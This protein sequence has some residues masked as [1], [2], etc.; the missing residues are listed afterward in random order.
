MVKFLRCPPQR[1]CR[2]VENSNDST[3][4]KHT[5]YV[6]QVSVH[7]SSGRYLRN[8][9]D[10]ELKDCVW[11]L[12]SLSP[13]FRISWLINEAVSTS[14]WIGVYFFDDS[15]E[16]AHCLIR[17]NIKLGSNTG[18]TMWLLDL[19]Q[20]SINQQDYGRL[21][22]F[23]YY[24]GLNLSCLAQSKPV[25]LDSVYKQSKSTLKSKGSFKK[26]HEIPRSNDLLRIRDKK[27]GLGSSSGAVGN[28]SSESE[29][30]VE[31]SSKSRKKGWRLL[32][33]KTSLPNGFLHNSSTSSVDR[34]EDSDTDSSSRNSSKDL[35]TWNSHEMAQKT[36]GLQGFQDLDNQEYYHI[37]SQRSGGSSSV[38]ET[39]YPTSSKCL[40]SA[41]DTPPPPLPPR[42]FLPRHR[43]LERTRAIEPNIQKPPEVLRKNKPILSSAGPVLPPRPKKIIHPEDTFGFEIV[44]T[45]ELSGISSSFLQD[46]FDQVPDQNLNVSDQIVP[47]ND[48]NGRPVELSV[49][50][51]GVGVLSEVVI[52]K[53]GEN[54]QRVTANCSGN[55]APG[56][57][58]STT[59]APLATPE[60]EGNLIDG[61]PSIDNPTND[62]N[63]HSV[64]SNGV[65]RS[66]N[67]VMARKLFHNQDHNTISSNNSSSSSHENNSQINN[68]SNNNVNHSDIVLNENS[69]NVPNLNNEIPQR[70]SNGIPEN[71]NVETVPDKINTS[72]LQKIPSKE[73]ISDIIH[74]SGSNLIVPETSSSSQLTSPSM[75]S[76]NSLTT[77]LSGNNLILPETS[78]S[79]SP[80]PVSPNSLLIN[81]SSTSES[82]LT[83]SDNN[84]MI[85]SARSSSSDSVI[86][87]TTENNDIND[88]P[89]LRPKSFTGNESPSGNI[90]THKP[91]SR[92]VSH[93]PDN[94][95][96][97]RYHESPRPQNR[98][99]NRVQAIT[100]PPSSSSSSSSSSSNSNNGNI[101][102]NN[103][104]SNSNNCCNS[105]PQCPPTPTHHARP[106][107]A[108]FQSPILS[109]HSNLVSHQHHHQQHSNNDLELNVN[110]LRD[111][112]D[113]LNHFT[114]D[115]INRRP[116]LN[117]AD[118][119]NENTMS[120]STSLIPL[121]SAMSSSM[122]SSSS[123]STGPD[124]I[125]IPVM[126]N[127]NGQQTQCSILPL[128]H[129][130]TSRLPSIPE[131][132]VR[133]EHRLDIAPDEESLPP[134][135][136]ARIDSHGRIFYIDHVNRM[137]TWQRPTHSSVSRVRPLANE[138]QRQQL[139]RR[140][141]S[142]RRTIT[143][144]RMETEDNNSDHSNGL[145][146][147]QT[148][149][150]NCTDVI[151]NA[152][153]VKF[154]A[155]PDFFSILHMNQD[156]LAL[157]NR[158][159]S[160]KHMVS[161]IRRDPSTFERYQHN[162]D[163]VALVNLFADS[164][165]D[166]PRGWETKF[167]RN[168]KAP[169]PPPR[170]PAPGTS[171]ISSRTL[172]IPTAYN[173]KVVA[174][175]RQPNIIDILKERH[176]PLGSNQALRDKV[177]AVR[178]EGTSALD[179][180]SHDIDLT[181]LLSLFEQEIMSYVP[182]SRSSPRGSPQLS[183]Q[184]SPG[185]SRAN[186]RAPAPYR[187]D[188]EAKLRNF[189]RKLESK[190]YGQGPGKLKLNIRREN[191][192]E[193]AF[194]KIMGASK[195]D[196]QKCKLYIQFDH[197]EGLDYGGPS[198]EFF[199]LLSRELFNPYYGLFEYSANDT[200]T[201]QVSPMSAFVDNQHE[202]F[203][204]SGR[205]LGLALVHQY[206]LDAFFTRPF[207]KA[208]L[209]LPVSLSDLESLDGEFH[210][211]LLWIKE[212][213]I[214]SEVLDLTFAVT[215]EV[216]GQTVERE[217]KPGG[218]N[219]PV[220]EK[221]KK[222]Y[223]ERVVRWRLERG[224]S[225]Q[226]ESL[227]RGF[228]EVVDPRLVSV[229][230]AR[231]LELVIAGTAE[232]DLADWRNHTEYRSGYH[233]NHPVIVWFWSA[234]E[235]FTNEQRLRLLQFVTGTSS[236]PYE[237]FAALRGSTGPR[238][239]SIE[240]WGKPNSLP[241]AHT[242]FNRLDLPPYPSLEIL[243]EKLLLAVEE[244]NTFGIE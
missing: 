182:A 117:L 128:R 138:L 152:P 61:N 81:T 2:V 118:T 57:S 123:S 23:R 121:P 66:N 43:P 221:N 129:I 111:S 242:C 34:I 9:L 145:A 173:D 157:Y 153:A 231:E 48:K 162:R 30:E 193:D 213:D 235:R 45:D 166:L 83:V 80:S 39:L 240:K 177:N 77:A 89:T 169:V 18:N 15:V 189:Y 132:T 181:I 154:L 71:D 1:N 101:S 209:R 236:V 76:P 188:F 137:T 62:D 65:V 222:E 27:S 82:T 84:P 26:K 159:G 102:I 14:D 8:F 70:L 105:Y 88:I 114:I 95:T 147:S 49:K 68:D 183:P 197:E 74:T 20:P 187:R 37:W 90:R 237:G 190:G 155:R 141:Q 167:D 191:L 6:N 212:R 241:R 139:D 24:S 17:C 207:Y 146:T 156:A 174:F 67:K 211:S 116:S 218:S 195:K 217:L 210:Q 96:V 7:K 228:Y 92:Q 233:D 73:N 115:S 194:N 4:D 60:Q 243:Y 158:N 98:L 112:S 234:I 10:V 204:F 198:R 56:A 103:S 143:S 35:P 219:I 3:D 163:L 59:A 130:T 227:V 168:G 5:L 208:L 100:S 52:W 229:F 54:L 232:I 224:V 29:S 192:L 142:I 104:L 113:N 176:A 136:E 244:T 21:L 32:K 79:T 140:Y 196:L 50:P 150:T 31:T 28:C 170:P 86:S 22:C 202:W 120:S 51:W 55:N 199:F 119:N 225:Q 205:V 175:L 178:V 108:G 107:R 201:V 239:F 110:L 106:I 160:L 220:T 38:Y 75:I 165:R 46:S 63:G 36:M 87:N 42:S 200:Y 226:T 13:C 93:P 172:E 134:Y 127:G 99:L 33:K 171:G 203:R 25:D 230:D 12:G 64:N 179:R 161:K 135:W 11:R 238:K 184:T 180:L 214:S 186:A 97:L 53:D 131:R 164:I 47:D 133:N 72:T 40:M 85:L 19:P 94:I 151:T 185:L 125:T 58:A 126:Q 41:S 109:R 16:Q 223:L 206:L 148:T 122:S 149:S 124:A 91:L 69:N 44:D 215:E 78:Q 144:R 216:F